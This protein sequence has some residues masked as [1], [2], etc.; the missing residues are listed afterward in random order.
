MPCSP[1]RIY[2]AHPL[3]GK[4]G[5]PREIAYNGRLAKAYAAFMRSYLGPG[6]DVYC[7]ADHDEM[8]QVAWLAGT[9]KTEDLLAADLVILDRCEILIAGNWAPSKG[10]EG[11]FAHAQKRPMRATWFSNLEQLMEVCDNIKE[12]YE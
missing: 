5:T 10:V 2:F 3:R 9:F 8:P 4:T 6:Y 11:E 7:P 12:I 1:V